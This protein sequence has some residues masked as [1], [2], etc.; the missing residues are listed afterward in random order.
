VAAIEKS[1]FRVTAR[2]PRERESGYVPV[3]EHGLDVIIRKT[4]GTDEVCRFELELRNIAEKIFSGVLLAEWRIAESDPKFFM[5]AFMYNRNRGDLDPYRRKGA[6][7][8]LFPRLSQERKRPPYSDYWMVRADRLSHP[9]VALFA[10][11]I[12]Y[13]LSVN[14]I[15]A[16]GP[17]FNGFS[18]KLGTD[19]SSIGFTLGYENAPWL[20][21]DLSTLKEANFGCI[22]V[23]P[24]EKLTFEFTAW[25]R[26][27]E[28][29]RE[30]NGLIR[31]VYD[32]YH[33]APRKGA[34]IRD[35]VKD[36]A[37]AIFT[38]AY[39]ASCQTYSTRVFFKDGTQF[40]EPL[41]SIS[42]TGGVEVAAPMLLAAARLKDSAMRKQA[43]TVIQNIVDHSMNPRSHLPY[44]AYDDKRWYTG[45]WWDEHLSQ[46]GHSSYLVGQALYYILAGCEVDKNFNAIDHA[47][48]LLFVRRCLAHI[49]TTKNEQ[50]E[51]PYIWSADDGRGLEYDSFA[52]CWCVAAAVLYDRIS[53]D[54]NLLASAEKSMDH[55][56]H[57]FVC[58][59]EC[60]GTP[61]DT[62]KAVDSEGILSFI[63][64]SRVLHE[65][66]KN[67][68]YLGMLSDGL[69]YEFTFK[70]CWNPPIQIDPLRR[71]GW[72]CCG[73]SVTS[74]CN[75]HIHP[76]SNNV[77]EDIKYCHEHT[78][79]GY[80]AR[81]LADTVD[82]SL[83]TYSTFDGE[84]DFGKKGWMSERFCHSEGLLIETYDTGEP[85][86]TWKCFLP[87]GA[88]NVIEGLCGP[89]WDSE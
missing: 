34:G 83:Q 32:E 36:I 13:G 44:D 77:C 27:A 69:E 56:Y 1:S 78:G 37:G 2:N 80:F 68:K 61:V 29:E 49:E 40:Q 48:W 6:G 58:A 70:F 87:W 82:W 62:S 60:Y 42:W 25:Q 8:A 16:L 19:E 51:V 79:D 53:P 14:P 39:V 15:S 59:M 21:V 10:D 12:L 88:S 55:Y 52:G 38:D 9:V 46:S 26:K 30:L 71:L 5:P 43:L 47:D 45:G 85:C 63:K 41:A 57:T 18:C 20:Y 65:R 50:G 4:S 7:I 75:P 89:V 33:Q 11:K 28:D 35:A 31:D 22:Q 81:R 67:P 54:S 64:A 76:M 86:S 84:Y 66:T 24:G 17:S 74:T 72:S 3:R 73:G 23:K